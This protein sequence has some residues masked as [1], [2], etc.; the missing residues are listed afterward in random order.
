[1]DIVGE[2]MESSEG[3]DNT[4]LNG[5]DDFSGVALGDV[6]CTAGGVPNLVGDSKGSF[7]DRVGVLVVG[8]VSKG[9]LECLV[10]VEVGVESTGVRG[11]GGTGVEG[12][13]L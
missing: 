7:E 11:V 6:T 5:S 12:T 1:M 10:G 8:V 3:G 4:S 13:G 2:L 9:S